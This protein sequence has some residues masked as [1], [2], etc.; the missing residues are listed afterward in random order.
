MEKALVISGLHREGPS[1]PSLFPPLLH[2]HFCSPAGKYTHLR[3]NQETKRENEELGKFLKSSIIHLG[4]PLLV[5][6]AKADYEKGM[7]VGEG[8]GR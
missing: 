3:P 6:L 5:S 8:T 4:H 7:L 1:R 2:R